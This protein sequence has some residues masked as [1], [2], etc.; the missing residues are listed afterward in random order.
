MGKNGRFELFSRCVSLSLLI[1]VALIPI[2]CPPAAPDGSGSVDDGGSDDGGGDDGGNGGGNGDDGG[3]VDFS[4]FVD[5]GD[6][7]FEGADEAPQQLYEFALGQATLV[8]LPSGVDLSLSNL[9]MATAAG[10]VEIGSD[11][12]AEPGLPA[13]EL[14]LTQVVDS[15]GRIVLLGYSSAGGVAQPI[16]AR[17]TAIALL[18]FALGGWTLPDDLARNDILIDLR[19]NYSDVLNE[20][21]SVIED[22]MRDDP[23][24]IHNRDDRI[25]DA[26][27]TAKEAILAL[28]ADESSKALGPREKS[29]PNFQDNADAQKG[30]ITTDPDRTTPQS[31]IY[32][33]TSLDS[34]KLTPLNRLRRRASLFAY[35]TALKS[36]S[37]DEQLVDPI[38]YTTGPVPIL[39][40]GAKSA[41]EGFVAKAAGDTAA[42][43]DPTKSD[44]IPLL[45]DIPDFPDDDIPPD[46]DPVDEDPGP[47]DDSTITLETSA[48]SSYDVIVVGPGLDGPD[49]PPLLSDLKYSDIRADLLAELDKLRW[50]TFLL[51]FFVPIIDE[52]GIGA[53]ILSPPSTEQATIDALR[54]L[55]EPVLTAAGIS[56]RTTQGYQAA[57]EECLAQFKANSNFRN[58]YLSIMKRSL[59]TAN[60]V[61]NYDGIGKNAIRGLQSLLGAAIGEGNKGP[62]LGAL[63][64]HLQQSNE[65]DLWR[66]TI[67]KVTIYPA[68]PELT[69]TIT[70]IRLAAKFAAEASRS[71]CYQWSSPSG[72]GYIGEVKGVQTGPDFTTAEDAVYYTSSPNM[73]NEQDLD[74]VT[75]T[76][77]DVTDADGGTSDCTANA[78]LGEMVSSATVIVRGSAR[79][80]PCDE[81]DLGPYNHGALTLSISPTRVYP[82][83]E[84]TVTLSYDFSQTI[85][86]NASVH[87]YLP[88]ACGF[89]LLGDRCM[90]GPDELSGLLYDGTTSRYNVDQTGFITGVGRNHST[91]LIGLGTQCAWSLLPSFVLPDPEVREVITHDFTYVFH[92][93]NAPCPKDVGC[94]CPYRTLDTFLNNGDEIWYGLFVMATEVAG[95]NA[96]AAQI[97]DVGVD[98]S[99]E[100]GVTDP[101]EK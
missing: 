77:F 89:C 56:I 44:P 32:L 39:P 18:Y 73:V 83:D 52:I 24:A 9:R 93:T 99:Y 96:V 88:Y 29:G 50:Q 86:N 63:T 45:S 61:A 30:F 75:V 38:E 74:P 22:A 16:S 91:G 11:G 33:R 21:T 40:S 64:A 87:L 47:V 8:E 82:G 59:G 54:S 6:P 53:I 41:G 27:I 80:D 60:A 17:S 48:A 2:G 42:N 101:C 25:L 1:V 43:W 3:P 15:S 10:E 71:Y 34:D 49:V 51:D 79:T 97:L 98:T 68:K 94:Y 100:V 55:V 36:A 70:Q 58:G 37:G 7:P 14:I 28:G 4:D 76:V 31:G 65:A 12:S 62:D 13:F 92:A 84:V 85:A 78:G 5:S 69:K 95:T 26:V 20:L 57:L 23:R 19:N 35:L 72:Y 81:F 46:D 67:S 90:C 66:V